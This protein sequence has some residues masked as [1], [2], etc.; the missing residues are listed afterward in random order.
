MEGRTRLNALQITKC[1]SET[2]NA[3]ITSSGATI[4]PARP[5]VSFETWSIEH[6]DV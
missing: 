3:L 5:T 6:D 4:L 2:Y 1:F